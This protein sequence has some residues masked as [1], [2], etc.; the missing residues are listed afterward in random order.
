MIDLVDLP[1]KRTVWGV[2]LLF[3]LFVATQV[4]A[5]F[6]FLLVFSLFQRIKFLNEMKVG[7]VS[8]RIALALCKGT[9][10]FLVSYDNNS[11]SQNLICLEKGALATALFMF[12]HH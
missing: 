6:I 10:L 1:F 11:E 2:F 3:F 7:N 9:F 12:L 8:K 4:N 5:C